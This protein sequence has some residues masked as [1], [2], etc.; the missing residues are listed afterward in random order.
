MGKEIRGLSSIK[1]LRKMNYRS[2]PKAEGAVES[3]LY[4]LKNNLM[5]AKKEKEAIKMRKQAVE[6]RI[7]EVE[8]RIEELESG[9]KKERPRHRPAPTPKQGSMRVLKVD[10]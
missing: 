10:Y 1:T 6:R 3:E 2:I 7:N 9:V 5:L 8:E 4:T